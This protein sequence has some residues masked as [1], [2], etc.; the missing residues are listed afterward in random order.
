MIGN[1]TV[2]IAN[3][4]SIMFVQF[5]TVALNLPSCVMIISRQPGSPFQICRLA[6]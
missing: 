2:I 6:S 5:N 3:N 4:Q 1:A